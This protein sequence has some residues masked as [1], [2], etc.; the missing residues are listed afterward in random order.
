MGTIRKIKVDDDTYFKTSKVKSDFF[1]FLLSQVMLT[2][3]LC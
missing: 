1:T 2:E 3:I